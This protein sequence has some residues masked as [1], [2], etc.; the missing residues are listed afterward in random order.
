MMP[1][2]CDILSF[3]R[4]YDKRIE[5]ITKHF[6]EEGSAPITA[7]ELGYR[8]HPAV[9]MSCPLHLLIGLVRNATSPVNLF[10]HASS[11]HGS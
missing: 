5:T 10:H 1:S 2:C 3:L 4:S 7:H 8:H 11:R 6:S 9:L